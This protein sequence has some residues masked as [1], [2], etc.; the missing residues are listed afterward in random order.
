MIILRRSF[1]AA[2]RHPGRPNIAEITETMKTKRAR[3]ET[4]DLA[5]TTTTVVK[6]V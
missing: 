4:I 5:H 6:E 2:G 1:N 3:S